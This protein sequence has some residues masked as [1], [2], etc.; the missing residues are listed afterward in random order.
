MRAVT[1]ESVWCAW[2]SPW[3]AVPELCAE[4]GNG[5]RP[6]PAATGDAA[7]TLALIIQ[8][9]L[10]LQN[11]DPGPRDGV[12]GPKTIAATLRHLQRRG[13]DTSGQI[14]SHQIP[15]FLPQRKLSNSPILG[16][17]KSSGRLP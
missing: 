9:V 10:A 2:C 5:S 6:A 1:R 16:T 15:L 7:T 11:V 14:P 13:I 8:T 4:G 3:A 12:L 17:T